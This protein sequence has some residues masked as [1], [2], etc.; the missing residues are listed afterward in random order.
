M[1]QIQKVSRENSWEEWTS[2][3]EILN[4]I[5]RPMPGWGKYRSYCVALLPGKNDL[6][7][8]ISKMIRQPVVFAGSQNLNLAPVEDNVLFLARNTYDDLDG[9]EVLLLGKRVNVLEKPFFLFPCRLGRGDVY[10]SPD[11]RKWLVC[12]REGDPYTTSSMS[13]K[14]LSDEE[15]EKFRTRKLEEEATAKAAAEAEIKVEEEKRER[16]YLQYR[17]T[18]RGLTEGLGLSILSRVNTASAMPAPYMVCRYVKDHDSLDESFS[19]V[20]AFCSLDGCYAFLR[21]IVK[22]VRQTNG[23]RITSEAWNALDLGAAL[24][25][26]L[27][28]CNKYAEKRAEREAEAERQT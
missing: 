10:E 4:T 6:A 19:V 18:I 16:E 13:F 11:G 23:G 22:F 21:N 24:K 2:H 5:P 1:K 26:A 7:R 12:G 14:F 20:R 27:D 15:F 25:F 28:E 9:A 17:L 8:E 3:P